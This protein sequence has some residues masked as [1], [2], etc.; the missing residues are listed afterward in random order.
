M[1][2]QFITVLAL[3]ASF[4]PGALSTITLTQTSASPQP[5]VQCSTVTV[6]ADITNPSFED[7]TTGWSYNYAIRTTNQYAS[8][9]SVSVYVYC[10]NAS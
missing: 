1:A 10:S 4:V 5:S 3:V 7:G 2:K 8:N 9:G 6:Y